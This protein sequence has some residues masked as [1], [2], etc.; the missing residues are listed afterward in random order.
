MILAVM[1]AIYAIVWKPEKFRSSTGFEPVT[2]KSAV[3]YSFLTGSLEP[4]N[5]QL[6]RSVAS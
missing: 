1:N 4:T 3:Q 2:I 5:D 6:P